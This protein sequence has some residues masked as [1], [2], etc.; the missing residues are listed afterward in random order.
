MT[1]HSLSIA[2]RFTDRRSP[3]PMSS[4]SVNSFWLLPRAALTI[5]LKAFSYLSL[6]MPTNPYSPPHSL[7]TDVFILLDSATLTRS[8][9]TLDT[10][11]WA[12]LVAKFITRLT[13]SKCSFTML[14]FR[15]RL[16]QTFRSNRWCA[17]I[18]GY[19]LRQ[20]PLSWIETHIM[21]NAWSQPTQVDQQDMG[22][23][24]GPLQV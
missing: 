12:K 15:V 6:Q 8:R 10:W 18:R 20:W 11:L 7:T 23:W 16:M 17:T 4:T 9:R 19:S 13:W 5:F 24:T 2:Y 21:T 22:F 1:G 14:F 3:P